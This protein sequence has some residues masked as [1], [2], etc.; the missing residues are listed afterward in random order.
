MHAVRGFLVALRHGPAA[1][2]RS[3]VLGERRHGGTLAFEVN[4]TLDQQ[5]RQAVE[6]AK[7]VFRWLAANEQYY[8]GESSAARVLLLAA[9]PN[10]GA[11][12]PYRGVFR[13]LSEEHVPFAVS[14]NM[15]WLGKRDFDL[16]IATDWAPSA[17]KQY[18]ESGGHVLIVSAHDPEFPIA[19]VVR[20]TPDLKG[21]IRVRD[22]SAFPSLKDTDLLMLDGPFTE[23]QDGGPASLTLIPPSRSVRLSLFTS[24]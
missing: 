13:L 1:G 9:R 17:L 22:H 12:E 18:A 3:A 20:T 19:S 23:V 14:E 11:V 5:D 21:Y 7:P 4:G 10:T 2:D 15:E 6:T 8:A 16:V 24:T